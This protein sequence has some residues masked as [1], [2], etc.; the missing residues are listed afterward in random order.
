M[1]INLTDDFFLVPTRWRGNRFSQQRCRVKKQLTTEIVYNK[2]L[3][4]GGIRFLKSFL[5]Y[6]PCSYVFKILSYIQYLRQIT[7]F[8][9]DYKSNRRFINEI[10]LDKSV[11]TLIKN[12]SV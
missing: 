2:G 11:R 10:D 7:I 1:I 8:I 5:I 6:N 9:Y 4:R 12:I 3:V